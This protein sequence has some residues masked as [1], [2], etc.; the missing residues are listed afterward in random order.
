MNRLRSLVVNRWFIGLIGITALSLLIWFGL[1]Y[2]KFGSENTVVSPTA[3]LIIIALIVVLWIV[4]NLTITI[5]NLKRNQGLVEDM[6]EEE[7]PPANPDEERASEEIAAI[8][9]RFNSALS[10]L[11]KAKFKGKNGTKSLYQLPWYIIIGPPGSGKTTAL[12]NSGLHFPLEQEYGKESIGGVG[13]TRNCD[14]WFT[15]EAVLID[16]AGRYTT[17]DS[18]RVIDNTAWNKFLGMLKRYRKRRPI[19]GVMLVVSMLELMSTTPEQQRHQAKTIRTRIEELQQNLGIRFPIY[20]TFTKTDLVAGFN[21][22]FSTLSQAEREQ[23]WGMSFDSEQA[24]FASKNLSEFSSEYAKLIERLNERVL[25]KVHQERNVDRRNL[26]LNFPQQMESMSYVLNDF[27]TQVFEPNNYATTPMLRGVYFT[28]AT[29]EGSPIDRMM[30]SVSA[31]FNLERKQS[32]VQQNTGKSYFLTRLLNDV[33]FPESELVGVN[34][35]VEKATQ[36]FRRGTFATMAIALVGSTVTW[37]GTAT[38]SRSAMSEVRDNLGTYRSAAVENPEPKTPQQA[39]KVIDPLYQASLI[40][41][42]DEHGWLNNLGMYDTNVDNAADKLFEDKLASVYMPAIARDLEVKLENTN[43]QDGN[44]AKYLEVYLMLFDTERQD[45]D[46]IN[47]FMTRM[48]DQEFK[49][50]EETRVNLARNLTLAL[51]QD[52]IITDKSLNERVVSRSQNKLRNI[53][54]AERLYSVLKVRP[55]MNQS[56]DI[57][58]DIGSDSAKTFGLSDQ[59]SVFFVPKLFTAQGYKDVDVSPNSKLIKEL[60]EDLWVYGTEEDDSNSSVDLERV[61]QDLERLYTSEYTLYWQDYLNKFK[62]QKFSSIRDGVA[63]LGKLSDPVYSPLSAIADIAAENTDIV[64]NERRRIPSTGSIRIPVSNQARAVGNAAAG[65]INDAIE[66][67]NPPTPMDIRFAEL[68]KVSFP[69]NDAPPVAKEYLTSIA[70]VHQFFVELDS[71]PSPTQSSFDYAKARFQGSSN[72]AI[73][74][75][76]YQSERAPEPYKTWLKDI[77][78]NS[79][80]V[81]VANAHQHLNNV[82]QAQVYNTYDR[83]LRNKYPLV[84]NSSRESSMQDFNEYFGPGGHLQNFINDSVKPFVNTNNWR[85]RSVNGRSIGLSN[86]AIRQFRQAETIRK[87]FF[88]SGNNASFSFKVKADQLDRGV[89][90]FTFETGSFSYEYSHGPRVTKSID[91]VGGESSRA[92]I[93]F[94]DLNQES[95]QEAFEGD[96]ALFKLLDNSEISNRGNSSEKVVR[97]LTSGR[98]AEFVFT[99]DDSVSP[100][101]ISIIRKYRAPSSL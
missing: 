99:P 41:D 59:D 25:L 8:S 13:G 42:S 30:S 29:Q 72:D 6:A 82:W 91:W 28:S 53:P 60:K 65:A 26:I 24:Q 43:A 23:V 58:R 38:S 64:K 39:L 51:E 92:R 27:L 37:V 20:M 71:S 56:F 87:A 73:Q 45:R 75:L 67:H 74:T 2:I 44:L 7:E 33:V 98:T 68:H 70:A 9:S 54:L 21:E 31:S 77:A 14:W 89:R 50:D 79:W 88:A 78:D 63:T 10:T 15:N 52:T 97:F 83:T 81:V 4:I 55:D 66:K 76:Y 17:Q 11:K 5:V 100:L 93:I 47:E 69:L 62:I 86:E 48:W 95:H 16:T 19:N 18:H 96:W 61:S 94:E 80:S 101:D 35:K 36:W 40:Y 34:K 32:V 3:R 57:Y 46:Y 22:F 1:G 49:N 12:I 84:S 90:L 85:Q